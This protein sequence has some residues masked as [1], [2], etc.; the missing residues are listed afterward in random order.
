MGKKN[1]NFVSVIICTYNRCQDLNDTLESLTKIKNNELFDYEIL[2]IDNNS[3]DGT[4]N[5]VEENVKKFKCQLKYFFEPMQGLSVARNRGIK[6]A[7]GDIVAFIDD[8][9]IVDENWLLYICETFKKYNA[10]LV[11][12]KI[13]PIWLSTPPKWIFREYIIGKLALLD[14]GDCEFQINSTKKEVYGT[15]MTFKKTSLIE[16]GLFSK[17]LGRR[18]D[19]LLSGE[20][21]EVFSNFLLSDKKIYYQPKAL[22]HHKIQAFRITK[23][24]FRKRCFDGARTKVKMER[25]LYTGKKILKIP[26]YLFKD[27]FINLF[28]YLKFI[29]FFNEEKSFFYELEIFFILGRIVEYYNLRKCH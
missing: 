9:C 19:N 24:Y 7:K 21:T 20:E 6:E 25:G 16:I 18:G 2:V 13:L 17:Q 4:K 3:N 10:D 1:G 8:D 29:V 27:L 12:G 14:Y 28:N 23:K 11:G 15:N 26:A 22:V 5:I